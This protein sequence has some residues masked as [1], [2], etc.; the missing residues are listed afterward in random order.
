[1]IAERSLSLMRMLC[2]I[3]VIEPVQTFRLGLEPL[4]CIGDVSM[5]I[6]FVLLILLTENRRAASVRDI[7]SLLRGKSLA[8]SIGV[9]ALLGLAGYFLQTLFEKLLGIT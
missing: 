6:R 1:V 2:L 9:S 5:M 7:Q 3:V 4:G 8:M